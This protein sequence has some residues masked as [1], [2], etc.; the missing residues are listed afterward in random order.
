MGF[1]QKMA[2]ERTKKRLGV[3][4]VLESDMIKGTDRERAST[5]ASLVSTGEEAYK[6]AGHDGFSYRDL[7]LRRRCGVV[8]Y[9][10]MEVLLLFKRSILEREPGPG[11]PVPEK[12]LTEPKDAWV[13]VNLLDVAAAATTS[14]K[15]VV[16]NLQAQVQ[17]LQQCW[18]AEEAH[19]KLLEE[20]IAGWKKEK[21][22]LKALR[23]RTPLL[24]RANKLLATELEGLKAE[25][26]L[27]QAARKE[28]R[29]G[30][31]K[32]LFPVFNTAWLAGLYRVEDTLYDILK[33]Q[34]VEALGKIGVKL[35]EP[36]VGAEFNPA[37]HNALHASQFEKG[38]KEI[39]AVVNIH[40]V[41]M[42]L[43]EGRVIE[44]AEVSVGVEKPE[45]E[46]HEG[47]GDNKAQDPVPDAGASG[48]G[49]AEELG[50]VGL[51]DT[52]TSEPGR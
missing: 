48:T 5:I 1:Y 8:L 19:R 46:K 31:I 11:D 34:L 21:E 43:K 32:E 30:I 28:D 33:K 23:E 51:P 42:M 17:R 24:E 38:S 35:I 47:A 9:K 52:G 25:V 39:G 6:L 13:Q 49:S 15:S 44:A 20:Q 29:L 7:D 10:G 12:V 4:Q 37:I 3:Y 50:S 40:R 45:E 22:D 41:G 2:D 18:Q 26:K 16:R 36:R 27:E 14:D